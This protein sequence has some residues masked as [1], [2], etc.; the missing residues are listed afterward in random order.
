MILGICVNPCLLLHISVFLFQFSSIHE[1]EYNNHLQD[2]IFSPVS[3]TR[4]DYIPLDTG[5]KGM[6]KNYYGYCPFW[7]DTTYYE[8]LQ[9]ELLTHI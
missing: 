2:A 6:L 5:T 9:M 3:N 1:I 4:L 7:I 8:Y